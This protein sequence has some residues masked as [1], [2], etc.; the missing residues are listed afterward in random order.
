M[1][2]SAPRPARPAPPLVDG[3]FR[4]DHDGLTLLGGRSASG[5]QSHFP[6]QPVCPWTGADDVEPVDL[7]RTGRLWGWTTVTAAPPGYGG[8]VP[9]DLGVVELDDGLRVV[10]R[11]AAPRDGGPT[12]LDALGDGQPMAV[13]ADEVPDADGSPR[14]VWA[15]APLDTTGQ[16]R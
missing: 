3:L 11:L 5:G 7:P 12:V 14:T 4:L 13:V 9:Y 10:G 16:D 2:D 15:F 6:L 8:E 1:T